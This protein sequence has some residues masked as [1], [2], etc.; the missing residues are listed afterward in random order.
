[1]YH[2]ATLAPIKNSTG[3]GHPVEFQILY[4]CVDVA[5]NFFEMNCT[6]PLNGETPREIDAILSYFFKYLNF[7]FFFIYYTNN[8]M[9]ENFLQVSSY[10]LFA[11]TGNKLL[12]SFFYTFSTKV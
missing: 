9:L 12:Q 4:R 1:M 2:H 8:Q 7:F 10:V 5:R 6:F 3:E 11:G